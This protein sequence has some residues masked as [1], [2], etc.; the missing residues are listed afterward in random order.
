MFKNFWRSYPD[1]DSTARQ[2][3]YAVEDVFW[4]DSSMTNK[5]TPPLEAGYLIA[6]FL[7]NC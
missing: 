4:C 7:K 6:I 1:G 5:D 2:K 3:I